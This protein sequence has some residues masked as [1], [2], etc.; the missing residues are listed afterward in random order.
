MKSTATIHSSS[1]VRRAKEALFSRLD[2][3]LLAIDA[4][5]GFCYA[6]NETA[7][8]VWDLIAMPTSI[9]TVC[10][11]LREEYAVDEA[12]CLRDVTALLQ[13]WCEAGLIKVSHETL[14]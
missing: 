12:T 10:A 5:A 6:M 2:D 13:D 1:I 4:Q 8:R 14:G 7:G 11:R 9:G 3:K